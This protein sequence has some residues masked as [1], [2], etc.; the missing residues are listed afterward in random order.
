MQR[1]QG[2]LDLA[3]DLANQQ[4]AKDCFQ[5][6]L[7]TARELQARFWELWAVTSLAC[8]WQKQDRVPA[9]RELL[10]Q[11]LALFTEGEST[12][13]LQTARGLLQ[14]LG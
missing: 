4:S 11:T 14:H 7:G 3:R 5:N 1:L 9:A 6:A 2:E 8:L 12:H 13:D 10:T